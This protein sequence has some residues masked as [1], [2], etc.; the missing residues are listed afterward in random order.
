MGQ[1]RT[2]SFGFTDVSQLGTTRRPNLRRISDLDETETRNA[3]SSTQE[4][5]MLGTFSNAQAIRTKTAATLM[6]VILVTTLL[7][8]VV[9][10]TPDVAGGSPAYGGNPFG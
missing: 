9:S 7:F 8:L 5:P 4:T 2:A 1:P 10:C 6:V 3:G